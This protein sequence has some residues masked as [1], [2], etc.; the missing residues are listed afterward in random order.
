[1]ASGKTSVGKLLAQRLGYRFID[2]GAMYRALTWEAIRVGIDLE[3][4][5]R[6]TQLAA[7]TKIR[8]SPCPSVDGT[9]PSIIVNE[10]D[11]SSAVSSPEVEKGVSIVS[12]VAGV[13]EWLVKRQQQM[14]E[15][16]RVVMVGRDIGTVV[17]P[18]AELKVFLL[19]SAEERAQ[20][21]YQE[22]AQHGVK[23]DYESVLTDQ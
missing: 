14:A 4:E 2:T 13:R 21:R 1:M 22:L 10:Q 8:L 3:D 16:G 6:L 20:R 9:Q 15:P 11:I 17:R 12:K 7:V 19:A 23:T 18:Q 5:A